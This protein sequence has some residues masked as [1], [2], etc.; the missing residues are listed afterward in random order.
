MH[1]TFQEL[2]EANEVRLAMFKNA[3][4]EPAHAKADGSDWSENDWMVAVTGEVGELANKLKKLRRGDFDLT[5]VQSRTSVMEE[6]GDII[7]YM[8]LLAKRLGMTLEECVTYTF[9]R[10]SKKQGLSVFLVDWGS[11]RDE[12]KERS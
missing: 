6:V 1:L 7:V 2:R 9:N 8:D 5:N 4:G 12:G 11:I 10:V 3:K